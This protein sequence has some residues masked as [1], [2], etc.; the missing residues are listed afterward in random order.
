MIKVAT[1]LTILVAALTGCATAPNYRDKTS[2]EVA[3]SVRVIENEFSND[4]VF[5]AP[6]VTGEPAGGVHYSAE[7][8]AIQSKGNGS[9][10]HALRV[11]WK[12][13]NDRWLFFK[14]A[15]LPGGRSLETLVN[16]RFVENCSASRY[17]N[18]TESVSAVVPLDALA[19][20]GNGLRVQ[21]G[22][23]LGWTVVELPRDYV[24]GYLQALSIATG[25]APSVPSEPSRT[26]KWEPVPTRSTGQSAAVVVKT[27]EQQ[28][29]ELQSTSGL[30]YEE[31]TRRYELIMGQ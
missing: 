3:H 26:P 12:Y 29:Q 21:F 13:G 9:V 14:S 22:S 15:T 25:A 1:A 27:K 2:A 8:A 16:D 5:V 4:R 31:Y 7:L 24:L 28:L 30:S 20:A 19:S 11:H 23:A 6:P 10:V 18:Y 17:C